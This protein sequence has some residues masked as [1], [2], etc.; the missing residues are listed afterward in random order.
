MKISGFK[1][2]ATI[3][4]VCASTMALLHIA[5]WGWFLGVAFVCAVGNEKEWE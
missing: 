1:I 5:G 4:V 2:V 3:A